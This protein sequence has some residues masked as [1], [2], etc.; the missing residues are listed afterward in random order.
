MGEYNIFQ[1][2]ECMLTDTHCHLNFPCFDQS[3]S[4]LLTQA[5]QR[6]VFRFIIPATDPKTWKKIEMLSLEYKAVYYA[7]GIHPQFLDDFNDQ[8]LCLLSDKLNDR[9]VKFIAIGEIG[10]HKC[11]DEK[12]QLQELVFSAQLKLALQAKLPV[13]LHIVKKQQRV[14]EILKALNFKEG[15]VYHAFSGSIEMA[16]EFIKLGFKL[17][18]G[19]VITAPC[20]VKTRKTVSK[21]PLSAIVLETDSPSMPLFNQTESI[22]TPLNILPI[23]EVLYDLRN[24]KREAIR[25]QIEKNVNAIFN[26]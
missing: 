11:S 3:L 6:G 26:V 5:Q 7:L 25:L 1:G 24:E 15:G 4:S 18:I 20:S 23:L 14:L 17:G 2:R 16:N 19:G 21:I 10:L 13:I 12:E 22:N 8:D 9:A